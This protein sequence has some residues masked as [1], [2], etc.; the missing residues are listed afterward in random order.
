MAEPSADT[1]LVGTQDGHPNP[2]VR[3]LNAVPRLLSSKLHVILLFALGLYIVVL[4]LFGV[5]V[6][7]KT[8]LIGG[9]YTNVTSDI[10][11][12]I[13]AGGTIHLIKK[14]REHRREVARLHAK[15][16]AVLAHHD[17]HPVEPPA[18]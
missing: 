7:S 13:A 6:S 8:E 17:I 10:G 3:A 4:P 16:D 11:A 14:N 18:G 9:N 5:T 15:R 2:L 1:D 12:C